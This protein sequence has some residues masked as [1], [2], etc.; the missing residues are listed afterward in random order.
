[1]STADD[2]NKEHNEAVTNETKPKT[3]DPIQKLFD[4]APLPF[5]YVKIP[6]EDEPAVEREKRLS[7]HVNKVITELSKDA[8]IHSGFDLTED[9]IRF[10]A[11]WGRQ[12][13][14]IQYSSFAAWQKINHYCGATLMGRKDRLTSRMQELKERV[15]EFADFYPESYLIPSQAKELHEVWTKYPL[16]IVKPVSMSRGRGIYLLSSQKSEPPVEEAVVQRYLEHPFIITGRKFDLRFYVLVTSSSPLRIY[17]HD[18]GLTRFATHKYDPNAPPEDAHVHLTN[19]ALNKDDESFTRAQGNDEKVE[20]SKWSIPFFINFLKD[21]GYNVDEIFKDIERVTISTII[22]GFCSIRNHQN[23]YVKHRQNTFEL[24]GI[25]VILDENMKSHV[26]EINISPGMSGT[27]SV[28]DHTIKNRLM[29]D[30]LRMARIIDCD[31]SLK[32]PCPGISCI[33]YECNASLSKER[34]RKVE[35]R[36]VKPCDDP[37][38]HDLMTVRDF[39]DEKHIESGFRRVFPKRKT[40]DRF[41][42]A[43]GELTYRDRMFQSWIRKDNQGRLDAVMKN[44]EAYKNEIQRI[45]KDSQI[46]MKNMQ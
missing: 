38:F 12:Y 37:V 40:M 26:L 15:G 9:K 27:D 42:P 17:M 11:A 24:Y 44:F 3:E 22:A 41:I 13:P 6:K 8:F 39:I 46:I 16:W 4:S 29:H 35:G 5:N 18:S 33:E 1:M 36:S 21:N 43:F 28:L 10:N 31:A 23:N 14:V 25:D 19:F 20:D 2:I 32:D 7:V 34:I 30:T 45:T